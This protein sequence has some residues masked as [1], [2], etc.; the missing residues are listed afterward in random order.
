MRH[1]WMQPHCQAIE[2]AHFASLPG[3]LFSRTE[4]I[5]AQNQFT[6][7]PMVL[8]NYIYIMMHAQETNIFIHIFA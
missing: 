2:L 4:T 6:E 7:M 8:S 5:N 3:R 1:R